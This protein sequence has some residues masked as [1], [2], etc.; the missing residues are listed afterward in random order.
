MGFLSLFCGQVLASVPDLEEAV[1]RTCAT[2]HAIGGH[3]DAA[4]PVVMAGQH[5]WSTAEGEKT[6]LFKK[7]PQ[8]P[9]SGV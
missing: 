9:I 6:V 2:R 3:A 8:I 4:H 1:P 7:P 5:S